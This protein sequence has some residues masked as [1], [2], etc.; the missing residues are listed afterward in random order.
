[1]LV[2][3]GVK[4]DFYCQRPLGYVALLL[5]VTP[6]EGHGCVVVLFSVDLSHIPCLSFGQ[7]VQQWRLRI[8][9]VFLEMELRDTAVLN[10]E[11]HVKTFAEVSSGEFVA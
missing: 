9:W 6:L 11:A 7:T 4:P 5:T 2:L 10:V 3:V 8:E 1:M